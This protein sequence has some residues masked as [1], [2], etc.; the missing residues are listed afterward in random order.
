MLYIENCFSKSLQMKK[1]E[2]D[3][4]GFEI[5]KNLLASVAMEK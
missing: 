4:T 1:E 2:N 3:E 5:S